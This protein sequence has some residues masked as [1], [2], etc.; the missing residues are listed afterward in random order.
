MPQKDG[1]GPEGKGPGTGRGLGPCGKG[2]RRGFRGRC[3]MIKE[4]D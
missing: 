3:R 1:T 2:R 4:E